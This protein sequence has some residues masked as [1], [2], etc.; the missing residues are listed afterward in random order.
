MHAL[1][2]L[3][4]FQVLTSLGQ[5]DGS[6]IIKGAIAPDDTYEFL[7]SLQKNEKHL[8]GGFLISEDFVLTAAHC[9]SEEPDRVV[10]GTHKLLNVG[11]ENVRYIEKRYKHGSYYQVS[12]GYDIMLLKLT[13]K[14]AGNKKQ[15]IALPSSNI[16]IQEKK[17]CHVAGWGKTET[18][19]GV[20]DRLMVVDVSV[21]NLN[22][23]SESWVQWGGIPSNVICA[24]GY[25]SD[26]GFCQGDSG[27]PLV[28]DG[29]AVGVVSF[30]YNR[31][32]D[33]P[34]KPNVY[35]EISKYL[36]WINNIIN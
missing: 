18:R 32:C 5:N 25:P 28:C 33:Y 21:I 36:G 24:G 3:L 35:T 31:T 10:V 8:C 6:R 9:S 17:T 23:C 16:H 4:L 11:D 2:K 29:I 19:G 22:T 20:V 13:R 7:V 30:N 1:H 27:G 15:I 12:G 26:K 14:V 34:T